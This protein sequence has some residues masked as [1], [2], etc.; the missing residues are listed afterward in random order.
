VNNIELKK[1]LVKKRNDLANSLMVT[2]AGNTS[3]QLELCCAEYNRLHLRLNEVP[4][5]I[6]KLF[7]MKEWIES[8]PALI[9][10]QSAIVN[11]LIVVRLLTDV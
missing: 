7:E 5:S 11:Q 1:T 8:L 2:H 9:K 6:E 3:D 10:T 4:A